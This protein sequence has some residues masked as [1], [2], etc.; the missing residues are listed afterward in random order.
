[1][2]LRELIAS[3]LFR[4]TGKV[5]FKKFL[6]CFFVIEGF[7]YMF[8]LRITKYLSEKK[9]A[10]IFFLFTR[11]ILRHLSHKYGIHIPYKTKIG[12]GFYIGHFGGIIVNPNTVFGNNI[13]ISQGVT[14]GSN[15]PKKFAII[16][17]MV[18]IAPGVKIIGDKKIG[19]CSEI[20]AN[21]V[22]T[23]DVEPYTCVAGVPAKVIKKLGPK[24]RFVTRI[25]IPK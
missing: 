8:F 23:K 19:T 5:S 11:L 7:Q 1:M 16:E 13:N 15:N 18:Y 9:F 24:P 4:Y 14:I 17:D 10:F 12:Y 3:D 22:V 20:G 6:Y 25:Y 21:A 2:K